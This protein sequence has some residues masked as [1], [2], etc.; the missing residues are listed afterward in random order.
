MHF[1]KNIDESD[2]YFYAKTLRAQLS[3]YEQALLFLN[4]LSTLGMKWEFNPE[5]D[6]R[7]NLTGEKLSETLK[8]QHLITKY[9]L[10]KNLPGER[11][12][13]IKYKTYYPEIK[14]ES[15]E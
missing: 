6:N 5:Y 9:N 2:K 7:S 11:I 12:F 4:S 14:Y 15:G 8:K 3:T 13:G 10:I 1:T